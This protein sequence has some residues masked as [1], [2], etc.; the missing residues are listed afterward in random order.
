MQKTI[1]SVTSLL[2]RRLTSP[3]IT[4]QVNPCREKCVNILCEKKTRESLPILRNCRKEI[5]FEEAKRCQNVLGDQGTQRM[6]D[7]TME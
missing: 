4:A 2:D 7:I 3:N 1:S 6:K 5:I